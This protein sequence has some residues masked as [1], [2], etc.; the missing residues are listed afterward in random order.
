MLTAMLLGTS[1]QGLC[2][3]KP[4]ADDRIYAGEPRATGFSRVV[5]DNLL[6]S[7][8]HMSPFIAWC[9]EAGT[10]TA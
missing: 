10:G 2:V 5:V 8:Q 1:E 4:K 6:L 3:N 7:S 9:S